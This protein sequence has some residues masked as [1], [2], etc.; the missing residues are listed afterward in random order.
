MFSKVRESSEREGLSES[1]LWLLG[2]WN[3]SAIA[4]SRNGETALLMKGC[5]GRCRMSNMH[6]WILGFK[7][8][9]AHV[10]MFVIIARNDAT[11]QVRSTE[12][13]H[14]HIIR[15]SGQHTKMEND[16]CKIRT[17]ALFPS[18]SGSV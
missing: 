3:K 15:Y 1:N 12:V 14:T 9:D 6:A 2:V 8:R 10:C 16:K 7:I 4:T 17:R 18:A 13:L 11:P 5:P